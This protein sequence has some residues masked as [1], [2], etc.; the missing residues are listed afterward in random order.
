MRDTQH[1][2]GPRPAA[3]VRA[4]REENRAGPVTRVTLRPIG[5]PLPLGF[6][7]L[8][9]GTFALA[10]LQLSWVGAAQ[11]ATVGLAV[12]AFVVPLQLIST[13][14]GFLARDSAA[15]TGMGVQAGSWLAIGLVT[16]VSPPGSVSGGLG[17]VLL[18]A[19]TV[20][21]IPVTAASLSKLLAGLVMAGT[22]VRFFLTAAYELSASAA[23]EHAAGV[24][25]LALAALALYAAMAFELE[26]TRGQT[27]LP[28]GRRPGGRRGSPRPC[29]RTSPG[30]SGRQACGTSSE[31]CPV[32][33]P[34]R[35]QPRPGRA[36]GGGVV[37]R[38]GR[39]TYAAEP[40]GRPGWGGSPAA[41]PVWPQPY[42]G[43]DPAV[44]AVAAL[45]W[46]PIRSAHSPTRRQV[47]GQGGGGQA[48][49]SGRPFRGW[50]PGSRIEVSRYEVAAERTGKCQH[51]GSQ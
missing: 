25:G 30:C 21:L 46:P 8:A 36:A 10:G 51:V 12:L 44:S 32:L 16:F 9:V 26:D 23:W 42:P 43:A 18:G 37:R 27:L 35:V 28:T 13:A 24:T 6:L 20:L 50:I 7:A 19:A 1:R 2:T 31:Q 48:A 17:L 39:D 3:R 38:V 11:Q 45:M 22:S 49:D 29:P 15:G 40:S 14:Y 34:G 5:S 4:G 33:G 41:A 47:L